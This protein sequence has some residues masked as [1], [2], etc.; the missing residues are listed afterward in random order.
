MQIIKLKTAMGLFTSLAL[1]FALGVTTSTA[2]Q[3]TK[4]SGKMT[5]AYTKQE[6][7]DVGDVEG[8][9]ISLSESEG[10]NVSTG[11]PEFMNGAQVVNLSFADL[12]KG[13]GPQ[14]GYVKNTKKGDTAIAKWE[15]KITTTLSA[16]GTPIT[17]FEG[18]FSWIKG[19]GQFENIQGNGTYKGGFISKTIYTVDWEGEYSIKK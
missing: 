12:V 15:G 6:R 11:K 4:V 17:T 3:K 16:E 9:L 5:V 10:I 8:H 7:I 14:Q 19:T 1:I 13:N 2:Q 18:T